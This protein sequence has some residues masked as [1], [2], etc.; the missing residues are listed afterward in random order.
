MVPLLSKE[1]PITQRQLMEFQP[2]GVEPDGTKVQDLSGVAIRACVEYLEEYV[3][4]TNG[5]DAGKRAV[6]ELVHRL[7]ERIPDRAF[8]VTSEFLRTPWNGYSNEFSAYVSQFCSDISGDPKFQFNF[9][10]E[11]AISPIIQTLGR[12]FTV[13]MIYR[14]SAY[15]S[16][17]YSKESFFTEAVR[18]SQNSATL[19]MT[20]KDRV[21]RQWGPYMKACAKLWCEG[22]KGYFAGVPEKFHGLPPAEIID[23]KCIAEGDECCE[24]EVKWLAKKRRPWPLLARL[25]HRVLRAELQER[26]RIIDEQL[27][28]LNSWDRELQEA[29]IQ[30]QQLTADLQRRVDH[31]TTIHETS[32]LFTSTLDREKLIDIVLETI[33]YKLRYDLVMLSFFDRQRSVIHDARLLGVSDDVRRFARSQE[34]SVTDPDTIEGTVLLRGKPVLIGN[35]QKIQRGLHPARRELVQMSNAKSV[36][37]VP[38]QVKNDM[39]GVLAVERNQ[40]NGLTEDDVNLMVTLAS[41]VAIALDNTNAY[42]KVEDLMVG[43]EAKVHARTQELEQLNQE[44]ERANQR[45]TETDRLK[46]IFLSHVSHELRTPLT[47][48]KGFVENMLLGVTGPLAEKQVHN[49]IRVK[50]NADRLI[51]MITNLLDQSRIEFGKIELSASTLC[52][53]ECVEDVI[54]QLRPLADEKKLH[55]ELHSM[56]EDLFLRADSDKLTQIFTNLL[57]NAIKYTPSGGQ[58]MIELSSNG[59]GYANI[60]VVDDGIGIPMEVQNKLFDPFFQAHHKTKIGAKGLGLGLSIAKHLTE[61]HGG[62]LSVTSKPGAGSRFACMIPLV[63]DMGKTPAPAIESGKSI[64]I[65][66]DDADILQILEDR[67]VSYGYL[68]EKAM[69]GRTALEAFQHRQYHGVLLDIGIPELDGLGVLQKMRETGASTPVVMITASGSKERAVQAVEMGAQAYLL[70]PFDSVRLKEVV[71]QCFGKAKD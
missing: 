20:F 69:D 45:L 39:M 47:S 2:F 63:S 68:V 16:E 29:Y 35:I 22:N 21:L 10:K 56:G 60:A 15:F 62:T 13:A 25:A 48:V 30:Q 3:T 9:A 5:P 17:R 46:S 8:H 26:D 49:L 27:K 36:V 57:D 43:L 23:V 6:E 64:L 53:R 44:L 14:M 40:E 32:L 1:H 12:P 59:Q 50:V 58:I 18:I 67:L 61:L 65:V 34:I 7:N 4:R 66:D 33:L 28:S 11:K 41:Q 71:E 42:R 31:L 55:L 52:L 37:A 38:L 24:W 19:R 51:R 70:K 54:A